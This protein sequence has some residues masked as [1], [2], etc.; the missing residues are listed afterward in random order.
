MK[1][2]VGMEMYAQQTEEFL[3]HIRF[4]IA[5]ERRVVP[6]NLSSSRSLRLMLRTIVLGVRQLIIKS[7]V[8]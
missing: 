7:T 5:G 2:V 8:T 4:H 3:A 1:T 6:N